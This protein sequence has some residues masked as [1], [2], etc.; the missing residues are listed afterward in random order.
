MK[1]A[2]GGAEIH[3][4]V[5]GKGPAVIFAHGLGG[6]HLSWWQQVAALAPTHTCVVF[7]H[8]GF[9]PSSA[10][11]GKTAPDAYADDLDALISRD[12][13]WQ[14]IA[15]DSDVLPLLAAL[16]RIGDPITCCVQYRIWLAA[17]VCYGQILF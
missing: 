14:R 8:R 17:L 4:E 10:V 16:S 1:L 11:S 5:Y 15:P 7:A 9:P 12:P 13:S 2:R 6:N 3:Y